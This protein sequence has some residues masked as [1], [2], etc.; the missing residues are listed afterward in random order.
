LRLRRIAQLSRVPVYALGGVDA[1]TVARLKGAPVAGIAA[2]G[3]LS[4]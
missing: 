4:V 2:I 3:A 1:A